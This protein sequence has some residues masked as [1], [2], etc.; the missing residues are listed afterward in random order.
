MKDL[1]KI[2]EIR[3]A[4]AIDALLAYFETLLSRYQWPADRAAQLHHTITVVRAR[5]S[6]PNL[7]LGIIGEFSSGKSTL[8]NTLMR[9]DFLKTDNLQGTTTSLAAFR[10]GNQLDLAIEY[11][12]GKS[13]VYSRD[14]KQINQLYQQY[15]PKN[16]TSSGFFSTFWKQLSVSVSPAEH[17]EK[18]RQLTELLAAGEAFSGDIRQLTIS[19]PSDALKTG[20]VIVDT[21]GIQSL[22][23]R[24]AEVTE[25]A[26]REICDV[27]LILIQSTIPVPVSL[28]EFLKAHAGDIPIHRCIFLVTK[29]DQIK[30][31]ERQRLMDMVRNKLASETGTANPKV[32]AIS[33]RAALESLLP[34]VPPSG[35]FDHTP[36]AE[37]DSFLQD[38]LSA[39]S[40]IYLSLNQQ[41]LAIQLERLVKLTATLFE[42]MVGGLRQFESSYAAEK[43]ALEKNTI[44]RLADFT[45]ERQDH[46]AKLLRQDTR[47]YREQMTDCINNFWDTFLTESRR[48]INWADSLKELKAS[49]DHISGSVTGKQNQLRLQVSAICSQITGVAN[50]HKKD[51]ETEFITIYQSLA[52]LGGQIRLGESRLSGT[53]TESKFNGQAA[54]YGAVSAVGEA[55]NIENIAIGASFVTGATIGTMIL[56]GIGTAIGAAMGWF[57]GKL[58]GPSLDKVRGECLPKI[59]A[60]I[61]GIR[62]QWIA[63]STDAFNQAV[64]DVR[65]EFNGVI[66]QYM[67]KY[68]LLAE[69]MAERDRLEL[70]R[71][72]EL[73]KQVARDLQEL[74]IRKNLLATAKN[75]LLTI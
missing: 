53:G 6:D 48:R 60:A 15:L 23:K 45:R 42:G 67:E 14:H 17:R 19:F 62:A 44:P 3:K 30:A 47:I 52:S 65:K 22:N 16:Q 56:P 51:F 4:A 57:I 27:A 31:G 40:G 41:K 68:R 69:Q 73:R 25:K 13:L 21:P 8:I 7:Y 1:E 11:N 5:Q 70:I 28:I 63:N 24:H 12:T 61:D 64:E 2:N 34:A 55:S 66:D 58:F 54:T 10:H 74:E 71:L 36:A 72:E 32:V 18:I 49:V 33:P 39:E 35:V 75:N 46:Y 29:I 26:I 50:T 43:A 20:L 38:Y 59:E 9:N 37:M